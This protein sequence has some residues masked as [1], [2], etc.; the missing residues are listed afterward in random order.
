MTP[1]EYDFRLPCVHRIACDRLVNLRGGYYADS[2]HWC[3]CDFCPFHED[4]PEFLKRIGK[5]GIA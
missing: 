3:M 4:V 2:Y 5:D 1:E